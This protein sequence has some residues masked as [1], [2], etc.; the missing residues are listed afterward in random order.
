MT[1]IEK[2]TPQADGRQRLILVRPWKHARWRGGSLETWA[3]RATTTT[4][5][6]LPFEDLCVPIPGCAASTPS[7]TRFSM[8]AIIRSRR[9]AIRLAASGII[10]VIGRVRARVSRHSSALGFLPDRTC[11]RSNRSRNL[12]PVV[13]E[14]RPLTDVKGKAARQQHENKVLH[15]FAGGR[16]PRCP[17]G[18][19]WPRQQRS[20]QR[21]PIRGARASFSTWVRSSY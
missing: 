15:R 1:Q 16:P 21:S 12:A 6:A 2:K 4:T 7:S 19:V 5:T 17:G 3:P 20:G 18:R 11:D 8:G 14:F 10:F 9:S 13:A